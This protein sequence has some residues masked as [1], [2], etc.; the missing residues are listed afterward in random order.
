MATYKLA[1]ALI[2]VAIG[3]VLGLSSKIETASARGELF[4]QAVGCLIGFMVFGALLMILLLWQIAM[5]KI[6]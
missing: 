2:N 3:I 5:I 1:E 4:R 6:Q